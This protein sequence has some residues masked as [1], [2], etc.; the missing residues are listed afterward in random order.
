MMSRFAM[1]LMA[2]ALA[3]VVTAAPNVSGTWTM[4]VEA[5]P[6]GKATMQLTLKQ[7]GNKVTGTF[8]SGH[9]PD[10]PVSGEF[11]DGVLKI[12]TEAEADSK[13]LFNATL[14]DDSN[15]AGYLSSAMGDMKW[16]ATRAADKKHPDGEA[17][18]DG[19]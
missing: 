19:R 12:A 1:T 13:I 4:S 10:L 14:K 17:G 9:S 15:L 6:H 18:K 16:T 3:G 11:A 5:G 7:E 8:A 2:A